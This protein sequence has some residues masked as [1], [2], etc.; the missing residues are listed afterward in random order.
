M[1]AGKSEVM[2]FE[3]RE[4]EV[5]DFTVAYRVRM[6]A[7][8]RCRLMLGREKMEEVSKFKYLGTVL[9]KHG[10]ME[11]EIRER[12]MKGRRVVGGMRLWA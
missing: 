6:P 9:C 2:V 8:A 1:N 4:G 7:V 3:R 10:G 11:G 12:V 5:I